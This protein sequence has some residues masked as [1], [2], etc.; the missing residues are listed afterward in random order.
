MSLVEP[1]SAEA[2]PPASADGGVEAIE[3]LADLLS[4]MGRYDVSR[5]SEA[6]AR[7]FQSDVETRPT[8]SASWVAPLPPP[9]AALVHTYRVGD[10]E[11]RLYNLPERAESLYFVVP[12][13]YGLPTPHMRLLHLARKELQ[14]LPPRSVDLRRPAE[15]RAYVAQVGERLLY[16]IA[17]EKDI[18]IGQD[19]SEEIATTRRLAE[20]LAKYTAGLGIVETLLRDPNVQ[21]VFVD[22]PASRTP[23][24]VTI[25]P[26]AESHQ[27][28]LTNVTLTEEDAE[29][30]LS[31][32]RFESGRPFSEATPVLE[33]NVEAF[34]VRATVVGKPLSPEG[35]AVAL[36]RH[37]PDPWT[38]PRL[39]RA[40]SLT[41]LAAALLSF[42]I[43]GRSTILIA[44][45]RGAG[46]SSLLGALMLEFP[47]AQRILTIE[48]TLELP[49][50]QMRELGY[51]VQSLYVESALGGH[52][53]MS[54][55][56]ALR[57]SLRLGESAII[58]GEVR[59][60]EARTLYEAM[61][62]GT[63][64]SAV[65][66]TIHGNSS[67][68]VYERIVHDLDIPPMSFMATDV[69]VIAG[70]ARPGGSQRF[71]RRVTEITELAKSKGAGAFQTLLEYRADSDALEATEAFRG[72]SERIHAI[73]RT[74][75]LTHAEA[76]EN[77]ACRAALRTALLETA[78]RTGR[79]D[80]L[81]AA[82]VARANAKHASLV[83]DGF[84]GLELVDEWTAWLSRT[85]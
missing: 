23:V 17:K 84:R 14:R 69:V 38:L 50:P 59:G 33:T 80:L 22:A 5:V 79:D 24:Y 60:Q 10:S 31:R 1:M 46:K 61:R 11:V 74:W 54:A 45:S 55:E 48:D 63:A 82:W 34:R 7:V 56:E 62:A 2:A 81:G 43:D 35:L 71:V 44:G 4:F 13:E 19:R 26:V 57:V 42:L 3:S 29:A 12:S 18:H 30:L 20:V 47:Q 32:F 21:D 66:G 73:A 75:N 70:L 68:S 9:D 53:E 77:I 28:C 72:A 6:L 51:K 64:G 78:A 39:I 83:E 67:S 76:M 65:M 52:G 25:A 40:G 85:V 37:S 16:R 49:G 58:L 8:F 36:R 15:I 41:P 27:R